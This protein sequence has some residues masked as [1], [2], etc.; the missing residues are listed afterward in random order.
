MSY[1]WIVITLILLVWV[2]IWFFNRAFSHIEKSI[3]WKFLLWWVLLVFVLFLYDF[4]FDYIWLDRSNFYIRDVFNI[5]SVSLFIAYWIAVLILITLLFKNIKNK[6]LI[7][8]IWVA[9]LSL[10]I[11]SLFWW[12]FWFTVLILYYILAA[13]TEEIFKFTV[14]NNQVESSWLHKISFLLFLSVLMWLSFSIAENV[15]SFIIQFVHWDIT[16]WFILGRWVIA[17]LIHCVSTWLIALM[18]L[19]IKKW[20]LIFKYFV[21]LLLWAFVH[22]VYNIAIVNNI[23]WIVF[24][25]VIFSLV[26][27][28]YLFF[29]MDEIYDN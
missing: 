15:F 1:L 22:I 24:V 20:W 5:Q 8:E 25:L 11:L 3:K 4:S 12:G 26:A 28:S 6:N 29:N 23:T 16:V 10:V 2:W 21:A 14:S 17:S 13:F 18:L 27:L 7:L 19:T 9:L